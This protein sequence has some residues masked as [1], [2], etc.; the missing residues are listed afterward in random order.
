MD[1][2]IFIDPADEA[3]FRKE[4][5]ERAKMW[6]R[7]ELPEALKPCPFCGGTAKLSAK[8]YIFGGYSSGGGNSRRG[9]TIRAI[10]NKCHAR[11]GIA[12]TGWVTS[13]YHN[14]KAKATHVPEADVIAIADAERKAAQLWNTR[15]QEREVADDEQ[16]ASIL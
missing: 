5:T 2:V 4:Q 12:K 8:D 11:G 7:I 3:R 14:F 9:Y 16:S 10:C 13:M 6:A 1:D 15:T